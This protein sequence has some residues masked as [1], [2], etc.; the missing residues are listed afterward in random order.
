[1]FT[2]FLIVVFALLTVWAIGWI[3]GRN[4][5]DP[6]TAY[7]RGYYLNLNRDQKNKF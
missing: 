6:N 5:I 7:G 3:K 1:M 4:Q 2:A